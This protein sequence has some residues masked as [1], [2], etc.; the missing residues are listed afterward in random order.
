MTVAAA[1]T[2]TEVVNA[3]TGAAVTPPPGAGANGGTQGAGGQAGGNSG[4]ANPPP[5]S[6]GNDWTTGL[7]DE[8]KS[9]ITSK[10]FK[11]VGAVVDSYR[12]FEKLQGVP[13]ENIL[14]L[15][16][17][18]SDTEGWNNVFNKLGRPSKPEEYNI[19]MP[20][21]GGDENFAKFARGIFHEAG[22][23]KGQGEKVVGKWNEYVA[24]MIKQAHEGTT[25]RVALEEKALKTEW[26]QAWEQNVKIGE[27]ASIKF[28]L[29]PQQLTAIEQAVGFS[30][31]MKLF[32]NIG[33][34][35][36]EDKFVTGGGGKVFTGTRTPSQAQARIAELR[37]DADYTKRYLAGGAMETTEM[38]SLH[39]EAYP[40]NA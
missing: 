6:A 17:D 19:P 22:L 1:T 26:G 36:G 30:A 2:T 16:K 10:G 7:P 32:H 37:Q 34:K 27:N 12:N 13:A 14:K 39:A 40:E 31:T 5:A 9:Y 25:A 15:P 28:G 8:T 18:A 4:A 3:G 38:S 24:G 20:E 21:K 33:T 35:L 23:T 29:S 11:D